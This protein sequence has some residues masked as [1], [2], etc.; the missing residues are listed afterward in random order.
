MGLIFK[1][2]VHFA[3]ADSVML[4]VA[5]IPLYLLR[6]Y[7]PYLMLFGIFLLL[8]VLLFGSSSGGAQRWLDLGFMRFQPSELM[9]I[10][11]PIAIASI[12]SE[13]TLPPQPMSALGSI[14]AIV[15]TVLLIAKQP[16]LGTSLLI[17]ASGLYVLFFS[18]FR[19]Q[20][21]KHN[22]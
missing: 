7:S 13:K 20:I 14:V 8:L 10:I 16:D 3:L 9:K 17:G 4:V 6:H 12:L 15:A 19:I 2:I 18:G 1:Q 11:V 21:I 22:K 5:Q